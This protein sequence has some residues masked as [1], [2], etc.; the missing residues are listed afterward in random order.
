MRV[1]LIAP[2][3]GKWRRL[4]RHLLFNGKTFRFSLLSLLSVAAE[5]PPGVEVEIV[6]E[7]VE[8]IPWDRSPD[9]VGISCMTGAAA[10]AYEIAALFRSRGV[11]VILGGMHPTFVPEEASQHADAVCVGEAEGVWPVIIEEARAGRMSGIYRR[12]KPHDLKGLPRPPRH[13]LRPGRYGTLHSVQAT[14]GCPHRCAFCS[15][16]AFHKGLF[17]CRPVGEVVDEVAALPGRFFMFVDDSLTADTGYARE[18]FAALRPLGKT[19]ITQATLGITDEPDL[20]RLAAESGCIGLFVGL[21][22]FSAGNLDVVDKGFNRVNE[23]R[24]RIRFL[25]GHGIGIEA[26][27]VF[28][29]DSEGPEIFGRTLEIIDHLEIDA[30]QVAILTPLPGTRQFAAMEPRI[31]DRNWAH[32]DFHNVVFQPRLLTPEALQAGHDWVTRE[33]YRPWRIARRL[34][35]MA[36][37]PRALRT[38]PFAAAINAAYYG[39]TV[40]WGIRGWDPSIDAPGTA[41]S[42]T[43]R[44]VPGILPGGGAAPEPWPAATAFAAGGTNARPLS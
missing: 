26:G 30:I 8:W 4:G 2:A 16:S 11:P 23:Y 32:Y 36:R 41:T 1:L 14:R 9:L 39:R 17:R 38:L 24:E 35:R 42:L 5:T 33:F 34:A 43:G 31:L 29:F 18:L 20:V 3:S 13:L 37:R 28:G 27:I 15:V 6:D 7:Q 22:T 21:E 44:T 10:R 19:W 40:R 12:E 25:H